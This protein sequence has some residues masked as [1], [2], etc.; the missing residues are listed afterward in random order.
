MSFLLL[1]GAY[2]NTLDRYLLGDLCL[3]FVVTIT[4]GTSMYSVLLYTQSK[5][6]EPAKFFHGRSCNHSRHL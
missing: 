4:A 3:F 1:Y 6:P 5:S 2:I